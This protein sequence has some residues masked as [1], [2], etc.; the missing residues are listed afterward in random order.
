[1]ANLVCA[2]VQK[3]IYLHGEI[4][5][6]SVIKNEAKTKLIVFLVIIAKYAQLKNQVEK[7]PNLSFIDVSLFVSMFFLMFVFKRGRIN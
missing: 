3:F 7:K 1:M 6:L 5:S 4:M 2:L